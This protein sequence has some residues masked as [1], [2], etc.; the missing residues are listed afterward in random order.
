MVIEINKFIDVALDKIRLSAGNRPL[1][2]SSFTPEVCI[3]LS[4]KQRAY[5]VMFIT[6]AG[7]PPPSDLDKRAASIQTAVHFA[8]RWGLAGVVFA[9][10][11]FVLCP[12]LVRFVKNAGLMCSTYGP[13]NNGPYNVKVSRSTY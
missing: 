10:E 5:P 13:Q 12:R 2:L 11:P 1:V 3:L 9:S 4:L 7:K 6:N 8:R